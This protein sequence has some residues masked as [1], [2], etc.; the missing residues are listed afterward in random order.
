MGRTEVFTSI[1]SGG[2]T[3][4]YVGVDTHSQ[5]HTVAVLDAVGSV[6]T[7]GT[8]PATSAGYDEVIAH[9]AGLGSVGQFQV[10]VE[11][12]NSYGAGLS[13]ALQA[14][15]YRVFE[16]LRPTRRVRRMDGKSDCQVQVFCAGRVQVNRPVWCKGNGRRS[17][18]GGV[19]LTYLDY[20]C[21][22][23][24]LLVSDGFTAGLA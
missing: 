21:S 9:L 5:T 23:L 10:G 16:V 15:G 17:V 13:R 12:T 24:R 11:G 14:A 7:T 2:E 18:W 19:L 3:M 4:F 22:A 8:Y 1:D 6:L 20:S